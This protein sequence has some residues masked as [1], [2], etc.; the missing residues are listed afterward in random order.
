MAPLIAAGF[1]ALSRRCTIGDPKFYAGEHDQH[2]QHQ[3]NNQRNNSNQDVWRRISQRERNECDAKRQHQCNSHHIQR[4]NSN[5]P[6]QPRNSHTRCR[7]G[8]TKRH[9]PHNHNNCNYQLIVCFLAVVFALP[10]NAQDNG[11]TA[12]ANPVA[13]ST[14]SVSNQAVQINQGGYSQQS[15]GIG[16]SCN[17]ATM[18]LTPFYLGN[19]SS[20]AES[21]GTMNSNYGAQISFSVPLDLEMVDLCKQLARRKLEKERVDYELTRLKNCAEVFKGGFTFAPGSQ[22]AIVCGDVVP[23]VAAPK[24]QQASRVTSGLVLQ[25]R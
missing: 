16:H 9:Y 25:P 13:T 14:G 18:V 23:I 24:T 5:Q 6:I 19:Q 21:A 7:P 15:F 22:F 1:N 12:I 11:T 3:P 17:S 2:Y 4:H 8:G 20:S 10:G